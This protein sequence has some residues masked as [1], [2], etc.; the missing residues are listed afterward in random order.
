LPNVF[1]SASKIYGIA[2][3]AKRLIQTSK[4]KI[5]TFGPDSISTTSYYH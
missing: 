4:P 2:P 5:M 3:D 1:R